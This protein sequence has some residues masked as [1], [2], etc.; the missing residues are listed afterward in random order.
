MSPSPRSLRLARE[1]DAS[2]IAA[3]YAPIV[4]HT[5]ISFETRAPDAAEMR[6]RISKTLAFFPWLVCERDGALLGYA[7]A[8]KHRE[9][10]AHQWS[11]DVSCYVHGDARRQG[12][13][14]ALYRVLLRLLA[15]QGHHSAFAGI[16]LPNDASVRLHESMGFRRIGEYREVGYKAGAWRD[17]GW[18]Q[19]LLGPASPDPAPPRA[20]SEL[21]PGV[22]HDL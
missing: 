1:D 8:T 2:A 12:V 19:C 22:L 3:I 9:R 7:Y 6:A 10:E 11:V 15:L 21:G 20:L 16:A 5:P 14:Q 4:R 17:T 18:F 13:G